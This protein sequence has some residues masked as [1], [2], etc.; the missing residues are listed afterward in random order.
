MKPLQLYHK[1]KFN[2]LNQEWLNDGTVILTFHK[3]KGK[4]YHKIR[5][6]NLYKLNEE[7]VD[8]DTG[9]PIAKGNL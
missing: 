6:K 1:G 7:E 3:R 4:K 9:E 5:V 8:I 2:D